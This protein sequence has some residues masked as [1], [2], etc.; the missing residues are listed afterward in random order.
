MH[1]FQNRKVN[2][3]QHN[4]GISSVM[5]GLLETSVTS[6]GFHS[7]DHTHLSAPGWLGP[8][9]GVQQTHPSGAERHTYVICQG[10]RAM[11]NGHWTLL[12]IVV[13]FF[14]NLGENQRNVSSPVSKQLH[15]VKHGFL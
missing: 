5:T 12:L 1:N 3:I 11:K 15:K 8:Q 7:E 2:E 6:P 4:S 9:P 10:G 13:E 14:M